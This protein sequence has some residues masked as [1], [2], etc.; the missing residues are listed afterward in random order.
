MPIF[1]DVLHFII[2]QSRQNGKYCM[3][4]AN[5]NQRSVLQ[6]ECTKN[7]NLELESCNIHK[8]FLYLSYSVL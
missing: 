5:V 2:E 7:L 1:I 4:S 3:D 6:I 8:L